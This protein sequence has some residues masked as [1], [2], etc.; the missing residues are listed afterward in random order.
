MRE[1]LVSACAAN[2]SPTGKALTP[3]ILKF[4]VVACCVFF[5]SFFIAMKVRASAG[6]VPIKMKPSLFIKFRQ[7]MRGL[8]LFKRID[9]EI[10]RIFGKFKNARTTQPQTGKTVNQTTQTDDSSDGEQTE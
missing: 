3:A 5:S 10:R 4:L 9:A 2:K 7:S 1:L 8:D 6:G